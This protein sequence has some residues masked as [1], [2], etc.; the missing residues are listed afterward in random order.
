MKTLYLTDSSANIV[1][2]PEVDFVGTLPQEDRYAI[3]SVYYIEE[4]MHVV[5]NCG[6]CKEEIDAKKGDILILF[7]S[8]KFNKYN[9][10]T[11]RTKQWVANIK[12]RR[13][14]EQKEKE[15]WAARNAE[16]K[17]CA[18]I[19]G[20]CDAPCYE[21]ATAAPKETVCEKISKALNKAKKA[22][23]KVKKA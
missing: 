9:I 15:E 5:Y 17:G 1:V 7:Y 23:K 22:V 13:V 16:C 21:T 18:D 3:R 10:D 12:N 14:L 19:C 8:N 4:P 6:E 11:I 2:D 20:D